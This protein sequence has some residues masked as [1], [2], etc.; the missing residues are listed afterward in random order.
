MPLGAFRLNSLGKFTS[1]VSSRSWD[2]YN[3][4]ADSS[5]FSLTTA[6]TSTVS[7]CIVDGKLLLCHG[8]S[9]ANTT[10]NLELFSLNTTPGSYAVTSLDTDSFT[11]SGAWDSRSQKMVRF[12]TDKVVLFYRSGTTQYARVI[13]CSSNT[14]S[15]GAQQT[16]SGIDVTVLGGYIVPMTSTEILVVTGQSRPIQYFTI[17]GDTITFKDSWFYTDISPTITQSGGNN[18]FSVSKIDSDTALTVWYDDDEGG[19]TYD[20]LNAAV[21]SISNGSTITTTASQA[22]VTK[23]STDDYYSWGLTN[24]YYDQAGLNLGKAIFCSRQINQYRTSPTKYFP[25]LAITTG[26][27]GGTITGEGTGNSVALELDMVKDATGDY[28]TSTIIP[29]VDNLLLCSLREDYWLAFARTYNNTNRELDQSYY[30][31]HIIKNSGT[32]LS[33]P[34]D[35]SYSPQIIYSKPYNYYLFGFDQFYCHRID[36]DT[37]IVV[38]AKGRNA[39]VAPN[40]IAACKII[41]APT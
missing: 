29:A 35:G 2:K 34:T 13:T 3:G 32:N 30:E 21:I 12:D 8:I 15:V 11:A 9:T 22:N 31:T 27:S 14:I 41:K 25:G 18:I 24:G 36:D 6:N 40:G 28:T 33:I 4:S 16:L 38:Y 37:A 1:T 39:T 7:S 20:S 23:S 5:E 17:S 26:T 10:L 19:S